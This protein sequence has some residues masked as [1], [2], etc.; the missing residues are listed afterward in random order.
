MNFSDFF[1]TKAMIASLLSGGFVL[2]IAWLYKID[3][4]I[5]TNKRLRTLIFYEIFLLNSHISTIMESMN[6]SKDE[7]FRSQIAPGMILT[8][9]QNLKVQE[10]LMDLEE[11]EVLA[12]IKFY[13]FYLSMEKKLYKYCE[14]LQKKIDTD[15]SYNAMERIKQYEE[16]L[17][18][19]TDIL[20]EDFD[21]LKA[22]YDKI[23]NFDEYK[24]VLVN[25]NLETTEESKQ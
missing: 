19:S 6:D 11:K 14:H 5:K 13:N 23:S 15:R 9:Y 12:I 8:V 7:W 3:Q 25:L 2:L 18:E 20:N 10:S 22:V 16:L 21:D 24:S 1:D 17:K 4:K